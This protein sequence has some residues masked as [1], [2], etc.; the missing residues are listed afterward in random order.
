M[1]ARDNSEHCL[2]NATHW[3][4][5]STPASATCVILSTFANDTS[6]PGWHHFL[7]RPQVLMILSTKVTAILERRYFNFS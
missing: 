2:P 1:I 5:K 3:H 4:A 7:G 6:S